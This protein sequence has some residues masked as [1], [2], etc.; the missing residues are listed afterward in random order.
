M[1]LINRVLIVGGTGAFGK[2]YAR[3]FAE[4]GREVWIC[5]RDFE[6]T[7]AVAHALGINAAKDEAEIAP[8]CDLVIVSVPPIVTPAAIAS[9]VPFC[10]DGALLVDFASVKSGACNALAEAKRKHRKLELASVHPLHGP[11]IAT[12]YNRTCVFIPVAGGP[13]YAELNSIFA[14]EHCRTIECTASEHDSIQSVVQGLTHYAAITAGLAI[15]RSGKKS[16]LLLNHATPTSE[17]LLALV[18]RVVQ[19]NPQMYAE[20][21]T[22]NPNNSKMREAFI[23]AA[24]DVADSAGNPVE[25][26]GVIRA[27]GAF[28]DD[29]RVLDASEEGASALHYALYNP[30]MKSDSKSPI[31]AGP[32]I[33]VLGPEGTFSSR[34][35]GIYFTLRG[36]RLAVSYYDSIPQVL[37]SVAAGECAEAIVP[38]ENMLEGSV[39]QTLDSLFSTKLKIKREIVVPIHHAI[40]ALPSTSRDRVV[41]VHSHPQALAQCAGYIYRHFPTAKPV[42]TGSTAGA[43][44]EIALKQLSGV[45]AIGPREVAEKHGLRILDENVEDDKNNATRFVVISR[46]DSP[47]TGHDKT[48]L[49][50][51]AHSD[52]PGLLSD[53]LA[54]FSSR[55][56]NLYAIESRPS[57]RRLGEYDFYVEVKGHRTDRQVAEA[58]K[59]LE[60]RKIATADIYGSYPKWG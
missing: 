11:R 53:L 48:S 21:Q 44:A 6:R 12:L 56:I 42:A 47:A 57:K 29:D 54:E 43:I 3:F 25:L 19:Q 31:A 46:S 49:L 38:I 36:E 33:A 9:V 37:Q 7:K 23:K 26:A 22:A 1:R 24:N 60:E 41:Q 45:A 59:S 51:H 14:A 52:R 28:F 2:W 55:K 20:I 5:G 30:L 18:A 10:K 58:I 40:A 13:K 8:K 27:A 39:K 34:A 17:L 16:G 4:R 50:L 32:G 15:A 35:A